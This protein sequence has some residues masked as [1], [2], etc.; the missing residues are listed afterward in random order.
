VSEAWIILS[1]VI[2]REVGEKVFIIRGD[3]SLHILE[4]A[5]A[6]GLW[7]ALR[8][9]PEAGLTAS[10]L[11]D[12]LVRGFVVDRETALGDVERFLTELRAMG[13]ARAVGFDS[14]GRGT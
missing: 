9:S 10:A 11:A 13:V 6:V 2:A 8:R 12:E 4:N 7:R 14:P 3:G 1:D 5:S